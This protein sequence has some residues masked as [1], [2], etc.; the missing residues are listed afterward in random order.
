MAKKEFNPL[1]TTPHVVESLKYFLN[2]AIDFSNLVFSVAL[3]LRSE[4]DFDRSEEEICHEFGRMHYHLLFYSTKF[5]K[6][7]DKI[8]KKNFNLALKETMGPDNSYKV[9]MFS[10]SSL[11]LWRDFLRRNTT[12]STHGTKIQLHLSAINQ[13]NFKSI[14]ECIWE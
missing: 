13:S 11:G 2:W 9:E 4:Q 10:T 1:I 8:V 12:L 5:P 14:I 6:T 7:M 3:H